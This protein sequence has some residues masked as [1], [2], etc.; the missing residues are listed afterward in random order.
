MEDCIEYVELYVAA[1]KAGVVVVP[2]NSRFVG[3]EATHLLDDTGARMLVWTGGM[4][5]KL[6]GLAGRLQSIITVSVTGSAVPAQYD[7]DQLAQSG[8]EETLPPVHADSLFILGYTSGTT[9]KPKGA[10]L[11]HRSVLAG[12]SLNAVSLRFTGHTV[13]ALT[14]SMSFVSIVPGHI[15]AVLLM[16]GTIVLMGKWDPDTLLDV[17]ER[18]RATFTYV[19]S[20]LLRDFAR[21]AT[22]RPAAL[23]SLNCLLHSASRAHPEALQAMLNAVGSARFVECWGMTEHSGAAVTATVPEDYSDPT[24]RRDMSRSVGRPTVDVA[25]RAIDTNGNPVPRDGVTV[26]ELLI[27]SPALMRGYWNRPQET[28]DAFLDGWYRSGDLGTIDSEGFVSIVERRTD[29]IVSGGMNVYPSEV[30][31]CISLLPGVQEVAVVGVSHERW[32]QAVFAAVVT[33]P[34][35]SLTEAQVIAHCREYL[36]SFK[37]PTQVVFLSELPKTT[38]AKVAR[39]ELR[40]AMEKLV[41]GNGA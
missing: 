31:Q 3:A 33:A 27:S 8:R 41:Q 12:A 14:G 18:E 34:G 1:G 9:G 21:A 24:G 23:A 19:P 13:H 37:K 40:D 4:D 22:E 2:I 7:F 35:S 11:T 20:P 16:G 15:V 38:S 17:I 5:E 39:G 10:M 36:A 32:G 29:L 26:G 28:A 6:H 30:E 25:V